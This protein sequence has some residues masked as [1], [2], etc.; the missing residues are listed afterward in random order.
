[1][2][3][4]LSDRPRNL[5]HILFIT[6]QRELRDPHGFPGSRMAYGKGP[7]KHVP[8]I[9]CYSALELFLEGTA[10]EEVQIVDW[11]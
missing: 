6:K 11:G 3:L 7:L 4:N 1:M 9:V 2:L 8:I 10:L 5:L